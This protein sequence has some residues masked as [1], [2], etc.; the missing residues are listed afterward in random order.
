M[1]DF[2]T[3]E[4]QNAR[5]NRLIETGLKPKAGGM[6]RIDRE[7]LLKK[8][9]DIIELAERESMFSDDRSKAVET[10]IVSMHDL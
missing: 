7:S 5:E 2:L 10:T 6:Q 9:T 4:I 8:V 1:I 3:D